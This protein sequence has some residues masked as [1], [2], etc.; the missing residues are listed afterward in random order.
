M[1]KGSCSSVQNTGPEVLGRKAVGARRIFSGSFPVQQHHQRGR[2]GSQH[3]PHSQGQRPGRPAVHSLSSSAALFC[4]F[5]FPFGS[6]SSREEEIESFSG[7]QYRVYAL[8]LPTYLV[9]WSMTLSLLA[10]PS[11]P[12]PTLS[13]TPSHP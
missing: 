4:L 1:G 9:R 12:P 11:P 3:H 7:V 13:Y 10:F 5:V 2:S 6:K 8:S